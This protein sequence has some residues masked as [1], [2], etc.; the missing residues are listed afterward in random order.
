MLLLL[1]LLTTLLL[2]TYINILFKERTCFPEEDRG[3]LP[4]KNME[5]IAITTG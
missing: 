2:L 5:S 3:D 1:T 4:V